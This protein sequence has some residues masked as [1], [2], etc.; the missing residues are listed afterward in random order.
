MG[1]RNSLAR[2][3]ARGRIGRRPIAGAR[4][5]SA[6]DSGGRKKADNRVR[7]HNGGQPP[8]SRRHQRPSLVCAHGVVR[9]ALAPCDSP[10][11]PTLACA[12][13]APKEAAGESRGADGCRKSGRPYVIPKRPRRQPPRG[14]PGTPPR[15][16]ASVD[17]P[18]PHPPGVC[19]CVCPHGPLQTHTHTHTW[20]RHLRHVCGALQRDFEVDQSR[21]LRLA[22]QA[23]LGCPLQHRRG[24]ASQVTCRIVC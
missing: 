3:A 9:N 14:A 20:P 17:T 16:H 12:G 21:A 5:R 1:Q 8:S 19:V 7:L 23:E 18:P 15:Q 6:C 2:S 24:R 22:G 13:P 11:R 4:R 10:L